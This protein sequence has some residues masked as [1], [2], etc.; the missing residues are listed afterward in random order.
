MAARLGR[1]VRPQRGWDYLKK[2]GY[3]AQRPRPRHAEAA[4]PEEQAA[5]KKSWPPRWTSTARR[6]PGGRS[7]S[8]PSTSTGGFYAKCDR[9]RVRLGRAGRGRQVLLEDLTRRAV[10]EA[11]PR[12]VVEPVGEPA[13]GGAGERL[14]RALARQEAA[15][16]AVQ[17]LDTTFL[18]G[19]VRVAEVAGHVELAG[20]LGVGGE[21]GPAVEGDGPA[22]VLG[23]RPEDVGDAGDDRR[24]ALVLVRQEEREAALALHERGHVRLAGLLAEDQQVGLPVPERVAPFDLRRPVLDPAFARDRR[25][26]RLAAVAR[27]APPARLGQVAEEAVLAA[28]G[29]VDVPVDRLVADGGAAVRRLPLEPAGD[30]L[31]RPA[32][33]QA[34]GHVRTQPVVHDQLAA[35][36]PASAGQVLGVQGKVAAEPA[37]AVAEAVAPQLPVDCRGMAAEPLGDLA[38]R[39]ASL[40]EAKEDASLF[41][42]DLTV[43]PGQRAP[44]RCKPLQRLGIRTSR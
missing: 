18:P 34:L 29:A 12:G 27:P 13:A 26:A 16:A 40:H 19:A 33:P 25:G 36:L 9:C 21:L 22:G 17:V 15:G 43:G 2:L 28:F 5:Y 31:R 37:V 42:I 11:A 8:G 7:R 32:G 38:D 3:S 39:P 6:S 24:R 30:L 1:E 10:A 14:G 20:E 4:S 23:Q 35:P 41:D 44:P